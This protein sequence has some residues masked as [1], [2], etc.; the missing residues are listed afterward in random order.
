[1]RIAVSFTTTMR[2]IHARLVT[3]DEI[4]EFHVGC[5]RV[6]III[7]SHLGLVPMEVSWM[8]KQKR[9]WHGECG[10]QISRD[11]CDVESL[12]V[13][14]AHMVP[15]MDRLEAAGKMKYEV[16]NYP[17]LVDELVEAGHTVWYNGQWERPGHKHCKN[18]CAILN[19]KGGLCG[20]QSRCSCSKYD[21]EPYISV[22]ELKK[23]TA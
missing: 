8:N 2:D 4:E 16:G 6:H 22:D 21:K 5:K 17:N 12:Y 11:L 15:L 20:E 23:E 13:W 7:P 3:A 19:P 10:L 9:S 14:D 18:H 1:M